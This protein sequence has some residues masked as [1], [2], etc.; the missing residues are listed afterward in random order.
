MPWSTKCASYLKSP[1]HIQGEAGLLVAVGRCVDPFVSG[2]T[3]PW[4]ANTHTGVQ[5]KAHP[6]HYPDQPKHSDKSTAGQS[7]DLLI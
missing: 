5:W 3:P 4:A 7:Q 1:L 2:G 6:I